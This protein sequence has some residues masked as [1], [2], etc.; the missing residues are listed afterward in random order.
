MTESRTNISMPV[1]KELFARSG[2]MCAF[3]DCPDPLFDRAG[4]RDVFIAHIHGVSPKGPRYK[5]N[6]RERDTA[7]NLL[8]LCNRHHIMIDEMPVTEW[9]AENV[10]KLKENHEVEVEQLT[11]RLLDKITDRSRLVVHEAP[12]KMDAWLAT[13]SGMPVDTID[14][15]DRAGI[16]DATEHLIAA[17]Q[18]LP[19]PAR[20]V[21]A[22]AL[23]TGRQI[24]VG[25]GGR[26]IEC[27]IADLEGRVGYKGLI[28]LEV[29]KRAKFG[30]DETDFDETPV[31][32]LQFAADEM[33]KE[34]DLLVFLRDFAKGRAAP[35]QAFLVEGRW[36]LLG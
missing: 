8:L 32:I 18:R 20:E 24:A 13:V 12:G 31:F 28:Q 23:G 29:L 6:F 35:L 3:P 17:V 33:A 4:L 26:A 5:K 15:D 1:W 11:A 36:S 34:Y 16:T 19:P 2:N 7:S 27:S 21:L 25:L 14:D 9:T 30:S 22:I 10:R